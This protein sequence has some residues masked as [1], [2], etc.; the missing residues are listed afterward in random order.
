MASDAENGRRIN[1]NDVNALFIF[2][3]YF[4]HACHQAKEEPY[5]FYSEAVG[6]IQTCGRCY[7]RAVAGS[8]TEHTEEQ[9]LVEQAQLAPFSERRSEFVE[10][11]RKL[12]KILSGHTLKEEQVVFPITRKILT[13]KEAD[14]VLTRTAFL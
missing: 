7:T 4:A 5:C 1:R 3:H 13:R 11:A 10:S 2:L 6:D 9:S 12:G 14:E 8:F